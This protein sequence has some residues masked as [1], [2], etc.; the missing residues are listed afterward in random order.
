MNR[1]T[2][3]L[4]AAMALMFCTSVQAQQLW[5]DLEGQNDATRLYGEVTVYD[6]PARWAT[7]GRL[8]AG[9]ILDTDYQLAEEPGAVVVRV[10]K[11]AV[12]PISEE[13]A[14][15]IGEYGDISGYA[16]AI[17]KLAAS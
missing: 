17:E 3:C 10:T 15:G 4:T 6:P 14:A 2:I 12:G 5:W 1:K 11:V 16:Q 13:D 8:M 7:R 9:T